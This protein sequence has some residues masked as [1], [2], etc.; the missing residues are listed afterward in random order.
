METRIKWHDDGAFL[1]TNTGLM[2]WLRPKGVQTKEP[3][4]GRLLGFLAD[5]AGH[6]CVVVL[7]DGQTKPR[8]VAFADVEID[9]T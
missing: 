2:G 4:M 5:P 3:K 9:I 8:I 1:R 6:P 7:E